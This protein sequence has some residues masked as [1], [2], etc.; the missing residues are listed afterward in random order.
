MH[1]RRREHFIKQN[2]QP[3]VCAAGC[4]AD[5]SENGSDFP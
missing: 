5:V 3:A 2:V 4:V 1:F